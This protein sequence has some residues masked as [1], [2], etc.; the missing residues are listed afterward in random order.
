MKRL[1]LLPMAALFLA[2]CNPFADSE[3]LAPTAAPTETPAAAA[4]A[5]APTSTPASRPQAAVAP[6]T[7]VAARDSAQTGGPNRAVDQ[8]AAASATTATL[9]QVNVRSVNGREAVAFDFGAVVPGYRVE[10]TANPTQ[11]G[12]GKPLP[13]PTGAAAFIVARFSPAQ[14]HDPAGKLTIP[15]TVVTSSG[16]EILEATQICDSEGVVSWA[17]PVKTRGP[18]AVTETN[19]RL[20]V[21]V[22]SS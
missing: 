14:A 9:R 17:I 13:M 8:P 12:S 1:F 15:N 19:G 22:G 5:P 2:A 10:Y 6:R 7:P 18:F 4:T 11:C 3:P 21:T 16:P 20:A